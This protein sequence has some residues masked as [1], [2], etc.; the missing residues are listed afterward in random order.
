MHQFSRPFLLSTFW[1][2]L[3][4]LGAP[5][6][7]PQVQI[8][9]DVE[10]CQK[11]QNQNRNYNIQCACLLLP[12]FRKW[13]P[14]SRASVGITKLAQEELIETESWSTLIDWETAISET[15]TQMFIPSCGSRIALGLVWRR[16]Q[17]KITMQRT[18]YICQALA[19]TLGSAQVWSVSI[20]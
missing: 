2:V 7:S 20:P 4:P 1:D 13:L 6:Y 17:H 9:E 8:H 15:L 12:P 14:T 18:T 5:F 10:K 3:Q 19:M 11:H 16:I